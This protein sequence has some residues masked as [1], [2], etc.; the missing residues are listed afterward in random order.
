MKL[1]YLLIGSVLALMLC[2]APVA[3]FTGGDY[4]I[5]VDKTG[6]IPTYSYRN[7]A[8]LNDKYIEIYTDGTHVLQSMVSFKPA[9]IPNAPLMVV[10][11]N[12]P[13]SI[14]L[15]QSVDEWEIKYYS[16]FGSRP[17]IKDDKD[18]KNAGTV[19]LKEFFGED[20]SEGKWLKLELSTNQ[21]IAVPYNYHVHNGSYA[22]RYYI[23]GV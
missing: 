2:I 16:S 9:N 15:S 3:V 14:Y 17:I 7:W 5:V 4:D 18:L 11:T 19:N 1:D 13:R 10:D 8:Y 12:G 21:Y 20:I 6:D 23:P 22:P